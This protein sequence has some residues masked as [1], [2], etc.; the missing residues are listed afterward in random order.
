MARKRRSAPKS[1]K[2]R[3]GH[4]QPRRTVLVFSEG[5]KTEVQYLEALRQEPE[6]RGAASVRIQ[7]DRATTG[8]SPLTLV[9]HAVEAR[10]RADAEEGEIDEVWC[11]FDVEWPRNHP[12]LREALAEATAGVVEVAVSNP[13]FELWLVLHHANYSKFVENAAIARERRKH[14]KTT[15]KELD[16]AL[17]MPRRHAAAKRAVALAKRHVLNGT[18]FPHDNP[19]SGMHRFLASVERHD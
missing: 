11:L 5:E 14:D 1:L 18:E 6:V 13:C 17:Y 10:E 15:G 7:I 4:L 2:R 9:R 16:G 19:S 3:A 8:S 12:N